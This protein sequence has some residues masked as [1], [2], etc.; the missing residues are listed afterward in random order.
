MRPL[1]T[2]FSGGASSLKDAIP[3]KLLRR[4]MPELDTLRGI[5]ILAVVFFHGIP[6]CDTSGLPRIV[7]AAVGT[8]QFGWLGVNLFFVLSG[9]LITGIL[10][11][12]K[13]GPQYY[14]RFYV[15]RAL[16]I[17]PAYLMLL[18]L[19]LVLPRIGILERRVS[20]SF[21]GVSLIY[22]SNL[23]RFFGLNV[24][25][26]P[27]WSL[28]VEEQFYLLW[29]AAVRNFS[30]RALT[31]CALAVFVG[32]PLFRAIGL[33]RG[34]GGEIWYTWMVADGLASGSLLAILSRTRLTRRPSMK[35]FSALCVTAPVVL[36]AL[37]TRFG[38][39][40]PVPPTTILGASLRGT[41]FNT[42]FTGTLGSA[43]LLG[44]SRWARI[45]QR[46][47]L[48]FFGEISY[49]LYL[50]HTMVFEVTGHFV[51]PAAMRLARLTVHE[52]FSAILIRFGVGASAA[53]LLAF[54][55]R[56]YF[57]EPFLKFK[58]KWA[59]NKVESAPLANLVPIQ[60][61]VQTSLAEPCCVSKEANG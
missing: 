56:R 35:W 18:L 16:R 59:A 26:A 50:I 53:T 14:K 46:P 44:T 21:V 33:A 48:Q 5:A 41:L 17:L 10:L 39:L 45:V 3:N 23:A 7:G 54:L 30:R 40:S 52:E 36:I 8:I 13:D 32:C 42:L 55:S 49:G 24:E 27:L 2:K 29:P 1:I 57:E 38:T 6:R 47:V 4:K 25:Y 20:W 61:V 19:L 37:G 43:L 22:L 15:R 31:L 58:D 34:H 51:T 60:P 11:D 12:S 28:A 9:F